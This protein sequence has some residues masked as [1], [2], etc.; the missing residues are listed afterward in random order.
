MF[1][2]EHLQM[3]AS[4]YYRKVKIQRIEKYLFLFTAQHPHEKLL[5]NEKKLQW[6]MFTLWFWISWWKVNICLDKR[7]HCSAKYYHFGFDEKNIAVYNIE[8]DS[9]F[10]F[11][12]YELHVDHTCRLSTLLFTTCFK[13]KVNESGKGAEYIQR[14]NF[15]K[16]Y[17]DAN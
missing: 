9:A 8:F 11:F 6:G 17:Q 16:L 2:T 1:L 7:K 5:N 3:T 10:D 14:V 4:V 13:R 15:W 12:L